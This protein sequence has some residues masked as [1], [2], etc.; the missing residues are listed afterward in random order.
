MRCAVVPAVAK[1]TRPGMAAL[2]LAFLWRVADFIVAAAPAEQQ[3]LA[4]HALHDSAIA[5]RDV[6]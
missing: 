1:C 5:G 6:R 3:I 4:A 2:I